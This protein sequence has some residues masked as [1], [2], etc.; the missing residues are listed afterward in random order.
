MTAVTSE[1]AMSGVSSWKLL[2]CVITNGIQ[3]EIS[4]YFR[5]TPV[6]AV[7]LFTNPVPLCSHVFTL[8]SPKLCVLNLFIAMGCFEILLNP[9][10]PSRKSL[11]RAQQKEREIYWSEA[12][13][14]FCRGDK[15]FWC[16]Y[17]LKNGNLNFSYRS[18][19]W[20]CVSCH[21]ISRQSKIFPL[22]T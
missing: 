11:S 18:E 9:S 19:E 7:Y 10:A 20:I 17:Q 12:T 21:Q 15:I 14:F 22:A 8:H 3:F 2:C 1:T 16:L 5:I 6:L 4:L 13:Y